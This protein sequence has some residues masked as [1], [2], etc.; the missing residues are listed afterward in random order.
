MVL[1]MDKTRP[2]KQA[3]PT[4]KNIQV[5][6]LNTCVSSLIRFLECV[7]LGADADMEGLGLARFD[8]RLLQEHLTIH[9]DL[10]GA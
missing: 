5:Y 9:V 2:G 6:Y 4:R 1:V 3:G 8:T 10:V 7:S